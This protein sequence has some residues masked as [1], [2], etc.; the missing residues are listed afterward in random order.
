M[1][2]C[3]NQFSMNFPLVSHVTLSWHQSASG[4]RVQSAFSIWD[5]CTQGQQQKSSTSVSDQPPKSGEFWKVLILPAVD[6]VLPGVLFRFE[7]SYSQLYTPPHAKQDWKGDI[8]S[9]WHV[10][11]AQLGFIYLEMT[12][13]VCSYRG[14]QPFQANKPVHRTG[15]SS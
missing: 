3:K 9:I 14:S 11:K 8:C 10:E 4:I 1:I 12:G 15:S 7:L 6:C 5:N 13:K 2:T